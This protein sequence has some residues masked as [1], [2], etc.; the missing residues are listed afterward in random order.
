[1]LLRYSSMAGVYFT[2][3]RLSSKTDSLSGLG[4]AQGPW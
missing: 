3:Q 1:V 2:G 4:K